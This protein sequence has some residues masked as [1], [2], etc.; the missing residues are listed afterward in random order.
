MRILLVI[1]GYPMRF[2]AGSEVYTQ[3]LAQGL[4]EHHTVQV[5]TRREDPFSPEFDVLRE[6]D[7]ADPRILLHLV[8][9][10]DG[11]DRYRR[12]GVDQR[13]AEVLDEFQPHVVHVGHLNHLSTSLLE[14][15]S[16]RDIPI[17]FTLHDYWL[18]CP[19]GQFMQMHPKD[20]ADVW[21]ACAGQHDRTCA[22]RCYARYFSGAAAEREED[23][24]HWTG[25]VRRR[26]DHVRGMAG[27]VDRFV[28]PSRTLMER[29][30]TDFGVPVERIVHL[31][32]GFDVATLCGR[33]RRSEAE[34]VFG[35]IGTHIPAKGIHH[36]IEAF[37]GVRG[38]ARLRIWGR[39]R[40]ANTE[41]LQALA[42][43][44]P[45]DASQRVEWR[46]EYRNADIVRQVFDHVDAIVVP[47]IWMENS[48]LVI[49]EALQARVPVVTADAGGMSELVRHGENGVLF[50]HRDPAALRD[51]MQRLVD[52]PGLAAKLGARGYMQSE[53]GDV[54]DMRDHVRRIEALYAQVI[55]EKRAAR[56]PTKPGPWRITFDTNP[57]ECNLRCIMCEEHSPH[58][59]RRREREAAGRPRRRMPLELLRRVLEDSRDTPLREIIPSTMGEPLVYQHFDD[60]V[61][62][63]VQH[64][65]LMNLTTNGTFPR[66][67]AREW[68]RRLVPI[69]SDVKI[70]WNGATRETHE[71]VMLGTRW[72]R[73]L[74]NLRV[75]VAERDAH[76]LAGGHRARVTLQLTFLQTNV[77]EL[78]GIVRLAAS[79]GVDR[80]KGHHL[81]AHFDAI[82]PLSMRRSPEAIARWNRAVHEARRA[83]DEH[84][85]PDGGRVLLENF[86]LLD[87]GAVA[88]MAP[89]AR[90]PF[91]GREA[92]VSAE[93]RFDPCCAPDAQRRTLGEFGDLNLVGIQDA[94][95]G[96]AYRRLQETHA[97]HPL[98][99]G[100]NMRQPLEATP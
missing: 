84:P 82:R 4:A 49:H 6:F 19:R 29:F 56:A 94:W 27:L 53:T 32:Y 66:R 41:A 65:L 54:T 26:M 38:P 77:A 16:L 36:L 69:L 10:P 28:A 100:C 73:V 3:A 79:L 72:E 15:A 24:A 12:D 60:L 64:G 34:F 68:A 55:R 1:H 90:C 46:P 9:V 62:L 8:N 20:P 67:G 48:P 31:E 2:N 40:G 43:A 93:G 71:A 74:E 59:G 58:S 45:A 47:S 92:W 42:A 76:A 5:F 22:E 91:L 14:Q 78:A 70:S 96:D 18:M 75:F 33:D 89:G 80:V 30:E 35:Y 83:A 99:Q 95:N 13:F 85:R 44:L 39:P 97:E 17:V 87:P 21:A 51:A 81:W 23:A 25:W 11:R 37:G 86:H 57:D 63:C 50:A 7:L 98:C 61:D 88:D 52:E